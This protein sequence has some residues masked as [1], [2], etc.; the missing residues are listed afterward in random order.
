MFLAVTTQKR[1]SGLSLDNSLAGVHQQ[2]RSL[3]RQ[4]P[5]SARDVSQRPVSSLVSFD[6]QS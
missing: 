5:L 4:R 2:M 1:P 6:L 3:P